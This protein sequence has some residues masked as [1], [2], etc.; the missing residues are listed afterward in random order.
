VISTGLVTL[1]A[2]LSTAITSFAAVTGAIA[3]ATALWHVKPK[4]AR[5]L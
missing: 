5:P 3:V 4:G 1:T 2:P